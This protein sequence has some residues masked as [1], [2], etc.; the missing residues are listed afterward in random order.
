M[1]R[2]AVF[3]VSDLAGLVGIQPVQLN[4]FIERKKYGIVQAG[5]GR[6]KDRRFSE[7]DVFGIALVW[8]LFESGLRSETIQFV[9]NQICG[10]RLN[11]RANNAARILLDG[12]VETLAVA[13][14]PRTVPAKHPAQKTFLSTAA[15]ALQLVQETSTASVLTVPVGKLLARLQETMGES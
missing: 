2:R 8:W 4:K 9:L 12:R 5:R 15:Q 1:N 11:S 13:R 3:G 10:G 7:E 14:E 6:G